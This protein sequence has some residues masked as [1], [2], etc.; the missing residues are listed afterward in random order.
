MKLK[1]AAAVIIYNVI[2][3]RM[4]ESNTRFSFGA[5]ALRAWCARQMLAK[6]GQNVNVERMAAFVQSL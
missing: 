6:C 2:A 1:R 4:P 5:R 3:R